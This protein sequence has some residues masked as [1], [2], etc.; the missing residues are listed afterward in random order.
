MNLREI[1]L[2]LLLEY[3]A[4]GKYV[5]LSLSS[6][7]LDALSPEERGIVTS[8]LYTTVEQR[9]TYDYYIAALAARPTEK[10]EPYTLAVLRLGACQIVTMEKIPD[11]AAVNETVKLGRN[12]GERAFINGVLRAIVRA[13]EKGELPLPPKGKIA[14]YLSVKYSFPQP[15]VRHFIF[16]FGIDGCEALLAY[17]NDSTTTDITVNTAKT[18]REALLSA[19]AERGIPAE[20]H[21]DSTLTVR[22]GGSYD[23]RRLP[24]FA[25]GHFFVQDA[26]SA[27]S[28]LALGTE[29][30]DKVVDTCA[31]PGGKSFAA[32]TLAG[33]EGSVLS[34]DL[35]E[36][37]L[38]LIRSGAE[39]LG[40]SNIRVESCDA[41]HPRV[42]LFGT[43]DRLIC[44]CPCSG[45][46]V[47]GK[48]ADMRYRSLDEIDALPELQYSILSASVG[49]LKVGGTLVYSTCTLNPKENEEVVERFLSEHPEFRTV[50]FKVG[51]L[52]SVGG[53]LTT[54]PHIHKMDGFFISK[55]VKVK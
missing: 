54:Y 13:K 40:L 11:F 35:H 4:S 51:S 22:L 9:I 12:K 43:F 52:A 42:E 19:L 50:D 47:L 49:Y 41:T 10:I 3:E 17:Y 36:S 48:K 27:I 5:N 45:L 33:E 14:R 21:A 25:E 6:H 31:A 37:K 53:M 20:A 55:M 38:S 30:G 29:K 44:D 39:R 46:G 16:L 1:A 32:A 2:S 34:L 18:T 28:A 15:L 7:R 23:P 26:A 24:G 8:L